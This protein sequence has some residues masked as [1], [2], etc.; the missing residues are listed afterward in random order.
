[1]K[2]ILMIIFLFGAS[3]TTPFVYCAWGTEIYIPPLKGKSGQSIEVPI[4][5]DKVDNL[6]GVKLVMS[7]D[8]DI[9]IFEKGTKSPQTDA[10]MHIVNDKN[11]GRLI[12]VMAGAR[13]IKGRDFP[14]LYLTFKIKEGLK[15]N[16]TTEIKIKEVQLMSDDL[17]EIETKTVSNPITIL[18]ATT[19]EP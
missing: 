15:G 3:F 1:M 9:F 7:Y 18:P 6:A 13:G 12:L 11:P 10:L 19:L 16:H 2:R 14:V 17:K 4:M 5:I 8:P